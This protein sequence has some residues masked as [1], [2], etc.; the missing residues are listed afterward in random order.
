MCAVR[1]VRNAVVVGGRDIDR[2]CDVAIAVG[3]RRQREQR[4]CGEKLS[5]GLSSVKLSDQNRRAR[6]HMPLRRAAEKGDETVEIGLTLLDGQR[7]GTF[8]IRVGASH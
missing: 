5:F 3:G 7:R 8:A 2:E 6:F 1:R 4:Q